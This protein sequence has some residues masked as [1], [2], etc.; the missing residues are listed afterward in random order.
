METKGFF[1]F[2]INKNILVSSVRF[3]S[4][5]CLHDFEHKQDSQL[6][7]SVVITVWRFVI[8]KSETGLPAK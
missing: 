2:E 5:H 6:D 8:E 3:I 1:H 7:S 4:I